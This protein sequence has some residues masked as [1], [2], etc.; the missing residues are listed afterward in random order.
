MSNKFRRRL[1]M[2]GITVSLTILVLLLT[3]S[4]AIADFLV[5]Y[6]YHAID[7]FETAWTGYYANGWDSEGYRHG[8]EP[9]AKME[10][11][12]LTGTG[13]TGYGA[14]VYVD[15]V[16]EDWMWW[17]AVHATGVKDF[18]MTTGYDP[19]ISVYMYDHGYTSGK[20]VIGQ[21]YTVPSLVTGPDDWT[22]VQCGGRPW[23]S[24]EG[25]YYYTWADS[26]HPGW[27]E[28]TGVSRPDLDNGDSPQWVHLKMQLSSMD[29]QIHYYLNGSEVGVSSRNDYLD[30]GTL[31]LADMFD[32]PLSD[33][34][35]DK[36]YVIFDNFE[37]GSTAIPAPGAIL[38]GS[39]GVGLV[40]WLRRR[41][42]L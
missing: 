6:P 22:D 31:V 33:W 27:Q 20:D 34:G 13:R 9:V 12:D 32:D 7:D 42:T 4:M 26:P 30:L 3:S 10:Q 39:L 5:T 37:Y 2:R 8:D 25:S 28:V 23:G 1:K 17:A 19:W 18:W 35:E 40:G 24:P 15:S 11:V 14:K 41:R 36:P 16:P 21:L 38:L 29:N